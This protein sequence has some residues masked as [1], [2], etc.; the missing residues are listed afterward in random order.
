MDFSYL[1]GELRRIAFIAAAV[2]I[3]LIVL[4]FFLS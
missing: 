2:T 1:G 4:S 3:L